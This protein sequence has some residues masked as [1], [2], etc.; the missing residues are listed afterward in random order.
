MTAPVSRTRSTKFVL[1]SRPGRRL[2]G[3]N[4]WESDVTT[5]RKSPYRYHPSLP[6][7]L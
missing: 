6:R 1:E 3:G 7:H 5:F 2:S 4:S